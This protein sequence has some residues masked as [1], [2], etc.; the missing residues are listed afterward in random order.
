MS[1]DISRKNEA[2]LKATAQSIPLSPEEMHTEIER[3]FSESERDEVVD[4]ET[5]SNGLLAELDEMEH[6]RRAG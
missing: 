6:K 2:R 4:G 1:I 3:G 5:F